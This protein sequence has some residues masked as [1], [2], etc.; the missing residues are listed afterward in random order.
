[1]YIDKGSN[2]VSVQADG[3]IFFNEA[4]SNTDIDALFGRE[5]EIKSLLNNIYFSVVSKACR[6][7][8]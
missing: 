4:L 5:K 6:L 1:M 7:M 2:Y 8:N 3:L